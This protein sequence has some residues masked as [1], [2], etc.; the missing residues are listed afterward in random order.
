MLCALQEMKCQ[1]DML[2]ANISWLIRCT[3]VNKGVDVGMGLVVGY[4]PNYGV[5]CVSMGQVQ[6]SGSQ[7]GKQGH[8]GQGEAA[9][10]KGKGVANRLGLSR[11]PGLI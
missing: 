3:E 1:V 4:G 5:A 11:S 10:P 9:D 7:V 8:V 6:L 2:Q